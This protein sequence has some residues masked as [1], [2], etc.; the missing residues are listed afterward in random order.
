MRPSRFQSELFLG[1]I[2][3]PEPARGFLLRAMPFVIWLPLEGGADPTQLTVDG[4]NPVTD[5]LF[6]MS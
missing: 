1:L 2:L 4:I 3:G 5:P 6:A